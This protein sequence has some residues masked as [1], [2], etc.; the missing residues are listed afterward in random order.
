M[1]VISLLSYLDFLQM[2]IVSF[3]P[4]TN[5][6]LHSPLWRVSMGAGFRYRLQSAIASNSFALWEGKSMNVEMDPAAAR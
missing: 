1:D 2:V 4:F 6:W 3:F 5:L